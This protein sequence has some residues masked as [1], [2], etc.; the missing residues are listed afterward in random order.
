LPNRKAKA[1]FFGGWTMSGD[2]QTI[3]GSTVEGL[4]YELVDI[5]QTARGLLRIF[6]DKPAGISVEDCAIVSNHLT[7]LF[8]VEGIDFERLEI[9]SPGLDRPLKNIASF[10]RFAGR[11][12]KVKLNTMIE[13]RR[14]FEGVIEAIVGNEIAFSILEDEPKTV[15]RIT[16]KTKSK[17]VA[18]AKT[19][20]AKSPQT[21]TKL[22]RVPIENIDRARLIPEV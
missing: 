17:A 5:E 7:R 12:A 22:L 10:Q 4:G 2:V 6:I 11:S 19:G 21:E 16:P 20:A 15:S 9:S 1:S 14:R 8:T 3:V 18:G 13:G